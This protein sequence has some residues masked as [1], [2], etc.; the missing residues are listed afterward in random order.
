MKPFQVFAPALETSVGSKIVLV[1]A[2]GIPVA[3]YHP[4]R[5]VRAQLRHT[6][7]TSGI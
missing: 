4:D 6:A 1:I 2:V 5:S 7:P 3:R